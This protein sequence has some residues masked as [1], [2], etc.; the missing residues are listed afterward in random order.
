MSLVKINK[1]NNDTMH[2]YD[3]TC[4]C[5]IYFLYPIALKGCAGIFLTYGIR[6]GGWVGG[7]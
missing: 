7:G 6:I 4:I 3:V 2:L 1:Y 5:D